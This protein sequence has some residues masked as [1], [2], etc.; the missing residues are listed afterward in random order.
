MSLFDNNS[1]FPPIT[2]IGSSTITMHKNEMISTW[3]RPPTTITDVNLTGN[4]QLNGESLQERLSRIETVLQI[5]IRD[6]EMEHKYPKLKKLFEEYMH[7]LE[8]LK[9]WN[10]LKESK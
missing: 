1:S 6:L 9:T 3:Q 4:A 2:T 10:T 8:K 5:P 7:E